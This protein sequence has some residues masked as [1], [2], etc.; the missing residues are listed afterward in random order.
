MTR[1]IK[2]PR[3]IGYA[4]VSTDE[5]TTHAQEIELRSVGCDFIVEEHGSGASRNRPALAKLVRATV[6]CC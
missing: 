3:L 6:R 5:Q 4:G 2:A 1:A